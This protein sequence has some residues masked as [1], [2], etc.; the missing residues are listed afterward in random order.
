[1]SAWLLTGIA[2]S[3]ARTRDG[4]VVTLLADDESR[5]RVHSALGGEMTPLSCRTTTDVELTVRAQSA[6]CVVVTPWDEHGRP[7]AFTVQRLR[8]RFP[9][10]P[11][12]VYCQLEPRSAHEIAALARAGVDTVIISGYDD[13]GLRLREHLAFA[14]VHR[15]AEDALAGLGSWRTPETAPILTY[16]I[17]RAAQPLTVQAVADAL[18]LNQ[19]TLTNRLAAAALPAPSILIQ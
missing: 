7:S 14:W 15:A 19:K 13:L 11:I 6:D 4:R 17:H 2:S 3:V 18:S 9:W 8:S 1:M 16:C 5:R 12:A 10:L